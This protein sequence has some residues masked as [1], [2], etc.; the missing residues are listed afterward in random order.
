MAFIFVT[1]WHKHLLNMKNC[2]NLFNITTSKQTH[3]YTTK[4][5]QDNLNQFQLFVFD[6]K[7]SYKIKDKNIQK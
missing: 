1:E 2:K 7:I 6:L 5:S 4:K 3:T